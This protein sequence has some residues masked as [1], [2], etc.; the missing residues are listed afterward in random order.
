MCGRES[1]KVIDAIV[2]GTMLNVCEPCSKFGRVIAIKKPDIEKIE[3]QPRVKTTIEII[4]SIIDDYSEKVKNAREKLNMKQIDLARQ[5]AEK[6]STI[7]SIEIGKLKP[8]LKLARKLEQFL[9]INIIEKETEAAKKTLDFQD[10]NLTI[11]DLIN[12]KKS[13]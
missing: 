11:G 4:E 5:I 10:K 2:E 7:H 12:V 9:R 1:E 13:K 8:T 3:P 6:E